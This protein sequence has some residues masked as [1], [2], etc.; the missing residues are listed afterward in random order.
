MNFLILWNFWIPSTLLSVTDEALPFLLISPTTVI[1][2]FNLNTKIKGKNPQTR[3]TLIAPNFLR[4]GKDGTDFYSHPSPHLL[5]PLKVSPHSHL[6]PGPGGKAQPTTKSSCVPN[7]RLSVPL[8]L[9]G[10]EPG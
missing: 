7:T 4:A 2:L 1:F 8:A 10:P 5:E 9:K 3:H 6:S